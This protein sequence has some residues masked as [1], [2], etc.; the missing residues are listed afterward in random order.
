M[1][2][3]DAVF[4]W[5]G[6]EHE[7]RRATAGTDGW[8]SGDVVVRA[9]GGP[10]GL[11]LSV[12]AGGMLS[13]IAL[14]WDEPLPEGSLVLGDAWERAYGDLRWEPPRPER[15][16]P[17]Y[18]LATTPGGGVRGAGVRVRPGAFCGWTA[19]LAGVTLWLDVRSGADPVRLAGRRLELATLVALDDDAVASPFTALGDL[20]SALCSDPLLPSAPVF[21]SN[22]WYYAYGEG[23][24]ASAVLRDADVVRR[25]MRPDDGSPFCVIDA[26]WS[27]GGTAPG[28]P[29]DRGWRT[30][31]DMASVAE[32]IRDAGCRPGLW[33]R[34]LLSRQR[35]L[36]ARPEPL[37]DAGPDGAWLLDPSTPEALAVVAESIRTF[38]A[39]G[40]ELIKHDFSTFDA[41]GAFLGRS[42]LP[43]PAARWGFADTSRTTAEILVD[44]YRTVREA[45]GDATVLGCNTVG[46]LAAGLEHVHR[47][48]D[49]TSGG[50]WERTRRM[51]V[52]ALAFRLAQHG[53]FFAVDADCVPSTHATP[54][55]LNRQFLELVAA[56]GTATFVS[57]DPATLTPEVEADLRRAAALAASGGVA[58][59]VEPLDWQSIPTPRRWRVGGEER[60]Y[61][62]EL[63]WGVDLELDGS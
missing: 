39:W 55:E 23:F 10:A 11:D 4:V 27:E 16:L 59:G 9:A 34:P 45:A 3:P 53:R 25:A 46:H 8:E 20:C 14:R 37:P 63:P 35:V 28:G 57:V 50:R 29:W 43:A 6:G 13:R 31:S 62:W 41:V 12:E 61:R 40:Y 36:G 51:G 2:L 56:S 32:S 44:L 7:P 54:W 33:F 18:W 5:S 48:G 30:F 49:D 52:N 24:D 17:W 1:P 47:A 38:R 21:G 42:D 22:N 15:V 19:D 60:T 26:G 58:G